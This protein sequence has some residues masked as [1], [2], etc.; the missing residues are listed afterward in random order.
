VARVEVALG[1]G[2]GSKCRWWSRRKRSFARSRR[3]CRRP[4]WI[5]ARRVRTTGG[6]RW[7]VKLGARPPSGRFAVAL[8]GIDGKGNRSSRLGRDAPRV[9]IRRQ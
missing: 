7:S 4:A 2:A 8:R 1:R 3:S 6:V 5:R 9:R